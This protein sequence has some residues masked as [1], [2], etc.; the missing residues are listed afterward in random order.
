MRRWLRPAKAAGWIGLRVEVTYKRDP[1]IASVVFSRTGMSTLALFGSAGLNRAILQDQVVVTDTIFAAAKQRPK[2]SRRVKRVK[3][4]DI[5]R[6]R[7]HDVRRGGVMYQDSLWAACRPAEH[8]GDIQHVHGRSLSD[9]EYEKQQRSEEQS[10]RRGH[11]WEFRAASETHDGRRASV[12]PI[13]R[14]RWKGFAFARAC[15]R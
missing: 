11:T 15:S 9:T 5:D 2:T 7:P 8:A 13:W 10:T 3:E 6:A 4:G 14:A 1:N 12:I